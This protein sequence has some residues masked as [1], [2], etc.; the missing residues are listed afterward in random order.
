[1]GVP[2]WSPYYPAPGFYPPGYFPCAP[3]D[4]TPWV[5][6]TVAQFQAQFFRDFPYA[7]VVAGQTDPC[8]DYVQ[9]QDIQNAINMAAGDFNPRYGA[10][11]TLIFLFLAA[12]YMVLTLRNSAMGLNSQAKFPLESS[13]VSG[14]ST[15]N[16]ITQKFKDDANLN[17]YLTTGYGQIYLDMVYPYTIGAG[18][19]FLQGGVS[20]N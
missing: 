1:M 13:T 8:L 10:N 9:P 18:F 17:K 7:P 20:T 12:H 19:N 4:G 5:P 6:P 3:C 15:V 2:R 14:V 16:N 11:T